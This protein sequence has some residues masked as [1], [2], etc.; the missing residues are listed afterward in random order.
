ML[1]RHIKKIWRESG[2][3]GP[4]RAWAKKWA[5]KS[6]DEEIKE[7]VVRWFLEKKR[8]YYKRKKK[9]PTVQPLKGGCAMRGVKRNPTRKGK[10]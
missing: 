3:P 7:S 5:D 8:P 1:G 10:K 2:R 4:L 9:G 6:D